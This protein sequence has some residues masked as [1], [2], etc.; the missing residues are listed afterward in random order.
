MVLH[1]DGNSFYAACEQIYRPDLR[2]K[3]VAVLSNNDGI[4]IALNRE[5][6]ACGIKRGDPYFKVRDICDCRGITIF[7]SNYTLY[8]D[9]SRRIT[10]IYMEFAPDIEEYSIDEAFLFFDDCNWSIR[11]YEEIGR[12]LRQ[13]IAKEVGIPICVGAAPTKTLAKLYN[14]KAKEHGGVFVYTPREVDA[15]LEATDCSTIWGIGPARAKKL[16]L[17]GIK[18]ALMLKHLPL[19]D[20]KRLLTIQGFAT[21]QELNGIRSIDKVIRE[22]KDIITSSRQFS[23]KVYDKEIIECAMVEYAEI[24]VERLRKQKSECQAVQV[25]I[26]TCNYYSEDINSQY[27]NAAIVQLPRLTSYTPDIVNAARLALPH[28]FRPG[29]G[30]K[31]VMITL[32]EIMPAQ[33][34]GWL[35]IDPME[36]IKKKRLMD[37]VDRITEDYGRHSITLGK[38]F[39]KDGWQMKR[40]FLSP[41]VTTDIKCIPGIS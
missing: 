22:K 28:I 33:Y 5:A 6:K 17:Y 34:Q 31:V 7:S 38:A 14:K 12:D 41:C 1:A 40:D 29:Y 37:A 19:R 9:I 30:Y 11:D 32:L 4:I 27:S 15:L 3:P 23:I 10:S 18:N 25:T 39:T 21:V 20:A 26:S 36:D 35:C 2:G 8:A 16:Q 24:A 13:R